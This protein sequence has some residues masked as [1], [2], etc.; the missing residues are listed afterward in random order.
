MSIHVG[1]R[2]VKRC[3]DSS[4]KGENILA[5]YLEVRATVYYYSVFWII[6]EIDI[7]KSNRFIYD[8]KVFALDKT[9]HKHIPFAIA[10]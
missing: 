6:V 1:S 9:Y 4:N 3:Q 2:P 5:R 7:G 8:N 10:I